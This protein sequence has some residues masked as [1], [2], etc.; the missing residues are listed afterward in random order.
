MKRLIVCLDGTWN[1]PG[2][3]K[4]STNVVKLMRA[5]CPTDDQGIKQITFYDKGVGTRGFC[6]KLAGGA[7]GSGLDENVKDGYRFLGNNYESGDEIYLFG[8]SRGAFTARSLAGFIGVCGLLTKDTLGRLEDAWGIYRK[9]KAQRDLKQLKAII[10]DGHGR[11]LITCLGVWDTVGALGI[12]LQRLNFLNRGKYEF[13]DTEL[14]PAVKIALHAVAI[15]EKRVSF[16]PALWQA[17]EKPENQIVEQVWFPG[18][19]SNIGGGYTDTGISDLTLHW[20]IQRVIVNTH[21]EFDG[22]Y[23][24]KYTT[25]DPMDTIY[26]SRTT[27]YGLSRLLPYQRVIGGQSNWV[28]RVLPNWNRPKSGYR[29]VGEKLH[30]S[31]ITRFG[32]PAYTSDRAVKSTSVYKPR[33]VQAAED[34]IE[35]VKDR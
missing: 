16:A 8:F 12:P 9:P 22:E 27:L 18:V 21:L 32:Q 13:H 14:G 28:R 7:F 6:D 30:Q 5:V 23:I 25:P 26:E 11:V 33:S 24:R 1:K 15:D 20:M 35:V 31:V 10:E 29:F 19:H 2:K 3:E 17:K 4:R 34:S